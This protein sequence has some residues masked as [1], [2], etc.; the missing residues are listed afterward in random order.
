MAPVGRVVP[1]EATAGHKAADPIA[2]RDGG[3]ATAGGI[4]MWVLA[5]G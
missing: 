4:E 5:S 2:G 1:A 3:S